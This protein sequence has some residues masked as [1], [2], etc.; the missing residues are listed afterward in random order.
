MQYTSRLQDIPVK[1]DHHRDDHHN[2]Q[3]PCG[4]KML[5]SFAEKRRD[6]FFSSMKKEL[7]DKIPK[8]F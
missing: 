5:L 3:Q 2:G 7:R 8:P 4:L 6:G 1:D